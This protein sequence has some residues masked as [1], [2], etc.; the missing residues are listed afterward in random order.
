MM[1]DDDRGDVVLLVCTRCTIDIID[2][3]IEIHF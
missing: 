2:C 1:C 3:E